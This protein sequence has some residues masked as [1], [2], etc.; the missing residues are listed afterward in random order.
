MCV[1]I[2]MRVSRIKYSSSAQWGSQ[3]RHIFTSFPTSMDLAIRDKLMD[4]NKL[5][6]RKD[7]KATSDSAAQ[8]YVCGKK[9]QRK[10]LFNGICG[11]CTFPHRPHV[12]TCSPSGKTK[13]TPTSPAVPKTPSMKPSDFNYLKASSRGFLSSSYWG[14]ECG[15][16]GW[17]V[18][19]FLL[20]LLDSSTG[21]YYYIHRL[22]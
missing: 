12:A 1:C 13:S 20:S 7:R 18:F 19:Y 14:G 3:R 16:D 22:C 21:T 17:M 2:Y 11:H 6:E 9:R 5:K 10:R 8:R 15:W 4:V